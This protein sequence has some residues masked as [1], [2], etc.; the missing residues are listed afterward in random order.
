MLVGQEA[1]CTE[2][3]GAVQASG[4]GL[5]GRAGRLAPGRGGRDVHTG[6]VVMRRVFPAFSKVRR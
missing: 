1:S 4:R 3:F 2:D 6:I 5:D